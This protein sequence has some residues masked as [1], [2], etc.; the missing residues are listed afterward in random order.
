MVA[1]VAINNNKTCD[2]N[3]VTM[4]FL[5]LFISLYSGSVILTLRSSSLLRHCSWLTAASGLSLQTLS[6]KKIYAVIVQFKL[7][8]DGFSLIQN[9]I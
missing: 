4:C 9:M 3:S 2:L 1:L 5:F 8:K 7:S 6:D